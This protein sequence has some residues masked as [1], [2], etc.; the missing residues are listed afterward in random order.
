[1]LLTLANVMDFSGFS[2]YDALC[3][4]IFKNSTA[5]PGM[6]FIC[7]SVGLECRRPWVCVSAPHELDMGMQACEPRIQDVSRREQE[8]QQLKVM[9]S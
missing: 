7:Q 2:L 4:Y 1:M 5:G 3:H 6:W 9:L 8:D